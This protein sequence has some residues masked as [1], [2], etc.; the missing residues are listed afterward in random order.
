MVQEKEEIGMGNTLSLAHLADRLVRVEKKMDTIRTELVELRYQVRYTPQPPISPV[1]A[2]YPWAD[3]ASQRSWIN[4][5][6][7]ALSIQGTP[8]GA[9]ILQQ[10]MGQSGLDCNELSSSLTAAREG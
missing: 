4:R 1:A 3:K 5:L 2:A 9:Q 7:A 10:R 8:L 6:F